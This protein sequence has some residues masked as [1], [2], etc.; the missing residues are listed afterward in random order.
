MCV[1][2]LGL[3]P[4]LDATDRPDLKGMGG[5]GTMKRA[6]YI[7]VLLCVFFFFFIFP[8]A[9]AALPLVLWANSLSQNSDAIKPSLSLSLSFFFSLFYF[10]F[11][12]FISFHLIL[13]LFSLFFLFPIAHNDNIFNKKVFYF[14]IFIYFFFWEEMRTKT[15]REIFFCINSWCVYIDRSIGILFLVIS[16]CFFGRNVVVL[17][18]VA[19]IAELNDA[20]R[21][22]LPPPVMRTIIPNNIPTEWLWWDDVCRSFFYK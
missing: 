21:L 2:V 20:K 5:T 6:I 13:I 16:C 11:F 8:T 14:Q 3:L 7:Y 15:K 18:I 19:H 4:L 10:F 1:Y 9:A 17:G 12:S 22:P